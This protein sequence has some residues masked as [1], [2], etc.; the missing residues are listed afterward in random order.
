M[1][2]IFDHFKKPNVDGSKY[3][4]NLSGIKNYI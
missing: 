2:I 1:K 3:A 4:N